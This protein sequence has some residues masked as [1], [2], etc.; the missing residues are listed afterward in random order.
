MPPQARPLPASSRL[1]PD[2]RKRLREV[3]D[4]MD[5]DGSD[6]L[7]YAELKQA[8]AKHGIK[9][10]LKELKRVYTESDKDASSGIDFDEFCDAVESIPTTLVDRQAS[11]KALQAKLKSGNAKE[12]AEAEADST[13]LVM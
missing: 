9:L 1:T 12:P 11:M 3:F 8:L 4:E 7:D 2:E 10:S 6:E 5:T 13:C